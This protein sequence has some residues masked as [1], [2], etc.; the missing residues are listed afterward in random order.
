MLS[1]ITSTKAAVVKLVKDTL[2]VMT[3]AIGDGSN[4]VAMI[5]AADVGVV[6]LVKKVDKQSCLQ[7]MQLD[8]SGIWQGYC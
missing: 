5:Q 2:N 1:C 7:I 3:L 6:L 8:N 4:D